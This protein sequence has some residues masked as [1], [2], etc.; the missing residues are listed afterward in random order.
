VKHGDPALAVRSVIAVPLTFR[1]R[2]FGVL[3]V[4]NPADDQPFSQS[5]LS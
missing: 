5:I 3:A 4:T 2:F 1:E